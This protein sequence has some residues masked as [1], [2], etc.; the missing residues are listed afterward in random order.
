MVKV[1]Y[2]EKEHIFERKMTGQR[3]LK[4]LGLMEEEVLL[5]RDGKIIPLDEPLEGEVEIIPVISGG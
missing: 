4:E 3:L 2:L 1:K 5:V